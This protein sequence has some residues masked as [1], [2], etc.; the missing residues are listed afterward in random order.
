[1][2]T[3]MASRSLVALL[4]LAPLIAL[5]GCAG[6]VGL[7]D[8]EPYPDEG[9]LESGV[10]G[11]AA[12]GTAGGDGATPPDAGGDARQ[13][14]ATAADSG[15]AGA[16]GTTGD[17]GGMDASGKDATS[18]DARTTDANE[19]PETSTP[20][21]VTADAPCTPGP[22]DP[23]NCGTCGHDCLGGTCS[24]SVCQP[25]VLTTG[26]TSYDLVV[27]NDHLYWVDQASSVWTCARSGA[28]CAAGTFATG[29]SQPERI[30]MGGPGGSTVFWTNYGTGV[31]ADGS[32]MSLPMSGSGSPA[33]MASGL[34]TPQGIAADAAYVYFAE[35]YPSTPTVPQVDQVAIAGLGKKAISTGASTGPTGVAVGGGVVYWTN[36]TAVSPQAA[37][38]MASESS[39]APTTLQPGASA[40]TSPYSIAVDASYV[41]WV[42]YQIMGAVWQ[43]SLTG[44]AKHQIATSEAYPVRIVTDG[45]DVYW[46]DESIASPSNGKLARFNV[47]SGTVS[48]PAQGL[49][50]P[51]SLA[52][53]SKAV[54]FTTLGDSSL[55]MMVR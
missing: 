4:A 22:S 14:D 10:E 38:G 50:Q 46:I 20:D 30:A 26:V 47:A 36:A 27:Q 37:V 9:G 53:D 18:G 3:R 16:D 29:Q 55:N 28:S 41:Y 49:Q 42:D 25:F 39:L 48:Y 43:S 6:L 23:H 2:G 8:L 32:V 45:V 24:A 19:P 52:M 44:T 35:S 40:A 21:V 31:A 51:T 13:G 15:D 5:A 11:G 12:D 34:W 1:M 17:G 54:Y 7:K 33:T